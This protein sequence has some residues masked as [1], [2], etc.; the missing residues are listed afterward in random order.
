MKIST[1]LEPIIDRNAQGLT[2]IRFERVTRNPLTR[3]LL[4]VM[5]TT[6]PDPVIEERVCTVNLPTDPDMGGEDYWQKMVRLD[7][8][9]DD[10]TIVED[11]DDRRRILVRSA[12]WWEVIL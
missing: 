11:R 7:G 3:T 4:G 6:S 5:T 2:S 9:P 8:I 10:A 1:G 12:S